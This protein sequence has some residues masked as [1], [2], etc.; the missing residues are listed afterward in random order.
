[1]PDATSR[2]DA[3]ANPTKILQMNSKEVVNSNQ[4]RKM[5]T[6]VIMECSGM[7]KLCM[8]SALGSGKRLLGVDVDRQKDTVHDPNKQLTLGKYET[9]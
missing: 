2:N 8:G 7:E 9:I 5:H 4:C 1:M 6:D 3:P